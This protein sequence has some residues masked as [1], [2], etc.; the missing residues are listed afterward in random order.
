MVFFPHDVGLSESLPSMENSGKSSS[1]KKSCSGLNLKATELRLGLPGSESPER[2]S[3][4]AGVVDLDKNGYSLGG[5]KGLVS[6]GAKRGFFDAINGASA[7]WVF[8]GNGGSDSDMGKGGNLFSPRGVNNGGKAL[9]GSDCN[10]QQMG[11]AVST[12]ND[13]VLP[14]SPKTLQEKKPQVSA[15][16]AK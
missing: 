13:V 10:N 14:Q 11:F 15:P 1:K 12:V 7:K 8:S 9:G 4:L 5:L 6:A 3:A 16:A 2:D